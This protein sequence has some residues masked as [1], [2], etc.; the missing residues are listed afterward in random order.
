MDSEK[1]IKKYTEAFSASEQF[2][3]LPHY[4]KKEAVSDAE[5]FLEFLFNYEIDNLEEI[6]PHHIKI[7]LTQIFPRKISA[8]PEEFCNFIP[9]LVSFFEFLKA[10]SLVKEGL[11]L[12]KAVKDSEQEMLKNAK[13][14]KY[15]GMAKSFVMQMKKEGVDFDNQEAIDQWINNYNQRQ[16]LPSE[17]IKKLISF[18][19]TDS[20]IGRNDPCPCG[21][22]K[23]YKRCCINKSNPS[24]FLSRKDYGTAQLSPGFFVEN[25]VK[26]LSAARLLYSCLL[27]PGVE[28]VA[29]ETARPF[30]PRKRWQKEAEKINQETSLEGLLKIMGED[31]DGLNHELLKKKILAF[32]ELAVSKIIKKL[33]ENEDDLFVELGIRIIYESKIDCAEHLLKI[34]DSISEPHTLSLVCL[35]L[36]FIGPKEAIQPV[37]NYYHFLREKYPEET[38]EQGPLLALYEF[39]ER[40]GLHR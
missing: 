14:P 17:E 35:L 8:E 2:L 28:Q 9:I 40:F 32:S 3:S 11:A 15:F 27:N 25:P 39:K 36:G 23:K 16:G 13:D 5:T 22:G 7:V 31:P 21:S 37:W 12:I 1:I 30:I 6:Q 18:F 33:K 19:K 24:P 34:L 26:E 38:Y 29:A 20:D 4:L 10:K